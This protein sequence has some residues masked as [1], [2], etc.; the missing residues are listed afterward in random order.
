MMTIDR[1]QTGPLAP[2]DPAGREGRT[3]AT[4][5]EASVRSVALAVVGRIVDE[6]GIRGGKGSHAADPYRLREVAD[7]ATRAFPGSAPAAEGELMRAIEALAGAIAAHMA[8]RVDGSTLE[9][10]DDALE[11]QAPAREGVEGV[12]EFLDGVTQRIE[13]GR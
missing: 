9:R 4:I 6:L 3:P 12:A 1:I 7:M 11:G 8:A 10:V 2:T 13:A 5:G